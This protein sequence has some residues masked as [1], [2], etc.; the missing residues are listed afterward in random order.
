MADIKNIIFDLG[1]VLIDWNPRYVYKDVFETEEAMEHFLG[2]ICTSE[3]NEEQDG[4]RLI[5]DA[6]A[7]LIDK[8]PEYTTEIL[9]FYGRWTEMLKGAIEENVKV[10]NTL[11]E[12]E[13]YNLYALTNWSDETWHHALKRFDFLQ[14]FICGR[15]AHP[16][17][18]H[19]ALPRW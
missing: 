19:G 4:G 10:L 12:Q 3:W 16:R 1:G 8:F 14:H 17:P 6:N 15:I 2:N 7:L 11:K 9:T 13:N 18:C 5:A